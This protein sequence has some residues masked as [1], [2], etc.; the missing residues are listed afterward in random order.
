[1]GFAVASEIDKIFIHFYWNISS[2]STHTHS[3]IRTRN[4]Y[5]TNRKRDFLSRSVSHHFPVSIFFRKW[6]KEKKKRIE[7]ERT[8]WCACIIGLI[9]FHTD[10]K[11]FSWKWN[12]M[13]KNKMEKRKKNV[14]WEW[15]LLC[16]WK[17][18]FLLLLAWGKR[19]NLFARV[20]MSSSS[21]VHNKNTKY[22]YSRSE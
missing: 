5:F 2:T 12:R 9:S 14:Y 18:N 20:F 10:W 3:L 11:L 21:L 6:P 13:M 16:M 19:V 7:R 8:N 17:F 1:M 22:W 15:K 4:V